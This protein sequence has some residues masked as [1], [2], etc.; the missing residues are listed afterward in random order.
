VYF[1]LK[2]FYKMVGPKN[3]RKAARLGSKAL[4]GGGK[5][6]TSAGFKGAGRK[7]TKV[8]RVGLAASKIKDLKTAKTAINKALKNL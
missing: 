3:K 1:F 7:A 2:L 5:L 8:G 4:I 6:A